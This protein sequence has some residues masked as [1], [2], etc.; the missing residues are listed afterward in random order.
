MTK[1]VLIESAYLNIMGGELSQDANVRREDLN[2]YLPTAVAR[3]WTQEMFANRAEARAEVSVNGFSSFAPGPEFYKE[4]SITPTKNAVTCLYDVRLPKLLDLP[5]N[6]NVLGA[7]SVASYNTDFIRVNSYRD[8][9]GLDGIGP[10]FY[11]IVNDGISFK[12]IFGELPAPVQDVVFTIA[13]SPEALS[14]TDEVPYPPSVLNTTINMLVAYFRSQ[15]G[16][17]ADS[18]LDGSDINDSPMPMGRK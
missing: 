9:I 10:V 6:W 1:G 13:I 4:V 7:R 3:A 14:M 11:W 12:A 8:A 17:P 5:N 16:T 2:A 15:R 18:K